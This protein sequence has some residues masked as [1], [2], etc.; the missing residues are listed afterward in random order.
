MV[1][2]KLS[3]IFFLAAAV[4]APV[5]AQPIPAPHKHDRIRDT[6]PSVPTSIR[7]EYADEM[8]ETRDEGASGHHRHEGGPP[9][10]ASTEWVNVVVIMISGF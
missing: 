2:I 4:I 8:I 10:D 3:I 9:A 6:P 1:Q 5:V 7:R